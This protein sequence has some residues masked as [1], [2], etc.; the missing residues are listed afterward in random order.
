M[1]DAIDVQ[2]LGPQLPHDDGAEVTV[3]IAAIHRAD[4]RDDVLA[5]VQPEQFYA[6]ARGRILGCI[7][8]LVRTG[9][10][11]D[12][13]GILSWVTENGQLDAIGGTRALDELAHETPAVENADHHARTVVNRWRE[14]QMISTCQRIVSEG[15][16]EHGA[17]DEWIDRA[18]QS[19]YATARH[20]KRNDGERIGAIVNKACIAS[21]R[22]AESGAALEGMAT[23]YDSLDEKLGGLCGG[24]FIIVAARPGMGK[25]AWV[26]SVAANVTAPRMV[27]EDRPVTV[28]TGVVA[29]SLE[30]LKPQLGTRMVCAEAQVEIQRF[31]RGLLSIE[32][33]RRIREAQVYL[34]S[35]PLWIDDTPALTLT[36]LRARARRYKATADNTLVDGKPVG[37]GMIV[38]DHIGLMKSPSA[39][40]NRNREQ[41]MSE[42]SAGLKQLAKEL[43]VPVIALSQ[44]N[45]SVESR[46]TKDKRPQLS[47]LRESGSLEQD[48]DT[49]LMLYRD[50]YYN[51]ETTN[52][53]GIAE[54]LIRKA[55]SGEAGGKV[56]ARFTGK[57][58]R[59]DN[60][61]GSDY[62][63]EDS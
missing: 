55:R 16:R 59:F 17:T 35:I 49:V 10:A 12:L 34:N 48:A 21:A 37:I 18:E 20:E 4:K 58:T 25:T 40:K 62:P 42:I 7:A 28:G 39:Q 27:S 38:V 33:W 57:Y 61:T 8:E 46:T 50:E 36:E 9:R 47:D 1:I 15:F 44:L 13:V 3:L 63:S 5:I 22:R 29:F 41:E 52:M 43:N 60:L 51:P 30:M 26:M 56:F 53:K 32:E 54:I 45:R 23:G 31:R 6:P 19:I 2:P 24:E 14:R 11:V